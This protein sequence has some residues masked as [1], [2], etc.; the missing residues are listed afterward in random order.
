MMKN[1]GS[2]FK[3]IECDDLIEKEMYLK[4]FINDLSPSGL[5]IHKLNLKINSI[6]MLIRNINANAGLCNG[7]RLVIQN[8]SE[9]LIRAI[10]KDG[11]YKGTSVFIPRM[12]LESNEDLPFNSPT[13]SYNFLAY[14]MTINKSQGQTFDSIGLLLR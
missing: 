14:A 3:K 12:M 2:S 6:L 4:E 9:N 7:T 5:S 13:I 10:I 11:D 8:L 1:Q